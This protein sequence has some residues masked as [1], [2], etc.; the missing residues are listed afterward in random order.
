MKVLLPGRQ[1]NQSPGT[2]AVPVSPLLRARSLAIISFLERSS[3]GGRNDGGRIDPVPR[4]RDYAREPLHSVLLATVT[5]RELLAQIRQHMIDGVRNKTFPELPDA[6]KSDHYS[7]E[8]ES[9]LNRL[10][11]MINAQMGV[12]LGGGR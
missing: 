6:A 8:L 5:P 1:W 2:R 3:F 12:A 7:A 10:I 9:Y 4:D 11:G